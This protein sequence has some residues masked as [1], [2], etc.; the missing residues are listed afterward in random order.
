[1]PTMAENSEVATANA[2]SELKTTSL[3]S[4]GWRRM[5]CAVSIDRMALSV[6]HD[7]R[8]PLSAISGSAELQAT[9][10]LTPEQTRRVGDNVRRAA[11]QLKDLLRELGLTEKRQ[12]ERWEMI[13]L[14]GL[15]SASCEAGGARLRPDIIL[16]MNVSDEIHLMMDRSRMERVFQDLIVNALEAM[17]Y[18]GAIYIEASVTVDRVKIAVEDTGPGIPHMIRDCLFEPFVTAGKADGMGLG[19]AISRQIVRHHGGDLWTEP[20]GGARFVMWLPR[21]ERTDSKQEE[22]A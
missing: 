3:R 22:A 14:R 12:G 6:L 15:L 16:I 17:P 7:L 10:T 21:G 11:E 18:C 2:V 13:N 4:N 1:M 9:G 19:L 20:S 5:D 8:N